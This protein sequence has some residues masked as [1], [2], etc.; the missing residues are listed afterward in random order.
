MICKF[1]AELEDSVVHNISVSE[2][3]EG[4]VRLLFTVV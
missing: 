4:S 1:I 2:D 3:L